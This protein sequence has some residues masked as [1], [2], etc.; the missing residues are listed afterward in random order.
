MRFCDNHHIFIVPAVNGGS[1]QEFAV[2]RLGSYPVVEHP[3]IPG[4]ES[5]GKPPFAPE[6]RQCGG[7]RTFTGRPAN[8]SNVPWEDIY[9][10]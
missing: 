1:R 5:G 10:A 8:F 4:L 6:R 7:S 3:S 9:R 2:D